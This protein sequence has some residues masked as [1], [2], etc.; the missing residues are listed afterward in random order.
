ML[1]VKKVAMAQ[2]MIIF[3]FCQLLVSVSYGRAFGYITS[4][5]ISNWAFFGLCLSYPI[6]IGILKTLMEKAAEGSSLRMKFYIEY[7]SMAFAALPFRTLYFDIHEYDQLAILLLTKFTYKVFYYL[8]VALNNDW[9]KKIW[10]KIF[11]KFSKKRKTIKFLSVIQRYTGTGESG[12]IPEEFIDI[13]AG[14]HDVEAVDM[15]LKFIL[16]MFSDIFSTITMIVILN[17]FNLAKPGLF[18]PSEGIKLYT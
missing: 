6:S 8:F 7:L 13:D 14:H 9:L 3:P 12:E 10:E 2:L 18:G 4:N 11:Q 1:S 5:G 16:L 17:I 15:G